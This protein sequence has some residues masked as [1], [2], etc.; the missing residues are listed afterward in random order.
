MAAA[1]DI[2]ISLEHIDA[3]QADAELLLL[4]YA[5][6]FFGLDLAVAEWLRSAHDLVVPTDDLE[7]PGRGL[8]I[9]LP[10]RDAT[11]AKPKTDALSDFAATF[12][13]TSRP[14]RS[15]FLF[16]VGSLADFT[17]GVLRRFP[18]LALSAL[19]ASNWRGTE[20][21]ITLHGVGAGIRLRDAASAFLDGLVEALQAEAAPDSVQTIRILEKEREPFEALRAGL[22]ERSSRVSS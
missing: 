22:V 2:Q 4:K 16:S 9:Q 14:P 13:D 8:L 19:S 21:A 3:F 18:A 6:E 10:R 20:V 17:T 12:E 11:P 15:V 7:E 5:G 1:Q